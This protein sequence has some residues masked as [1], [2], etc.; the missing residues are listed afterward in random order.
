[1]PGARPNALITIADD[2]GLFDVGLLPPEGDGGDDGQHRPDC[3]RRGPLTDRTAPA[4]CTVAGPLITGQLP[5]R[6]GLSTVGMSAA[7]RGHQAKEPPVAE[8]WKPLHCFRDPAHAL[9]SG[10]TGRDWL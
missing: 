4:S 5:M 7:T 2:I 10:T 1:M 3:R 8:L 9:P 6:T